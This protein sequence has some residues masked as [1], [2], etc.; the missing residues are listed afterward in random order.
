MAQETHNNAPNF[1]APSIRDE[2]ALRELEAARGVISRIDLETDE[3]VR[4]AA[5]GLKNFGPP[6]FEN[7]AIEAQAKD[8]FVTATKAAGF[9][10]G[11]SD[12]IWRRTTA[13]ESAIETLVK[14]QVESIETSRP[15]RVTRQRKKSITSFMRF[16]TNKISTFYMKK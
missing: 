5:A 2:Q 15:K 6:K 11:K 12:R 9:S 3:D 13:D 10:F 4:L 7:P 14:Y 1:F 16:S 8:I